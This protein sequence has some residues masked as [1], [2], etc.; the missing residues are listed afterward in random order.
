MK[1]VHHRAFRARGLTL[2]DLRIRISLMIPSS[3]PLGRERVWTERGKETK[4][5]TRD[6]RAYAATRQ[7]VL[8]P[9]HQSMALRDS[10]LKTSLRALVRK[11]PTFTSP[12]I[13]QYYARSILSLYRLLESGTRLSD[14]LRCCG[15]GSVCLTPSI[16]HMHST[17]G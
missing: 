15:S 16:A 10:G 4:T 1:V 5:K 14:Y 8:E 17:W 2:L 7:Q 11:P 3:P 6:N 9:P 12:L 13:L